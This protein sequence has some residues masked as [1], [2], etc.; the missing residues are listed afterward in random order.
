[1][2]LVQIAL[3]GAMVGVPLGYAMQRTNLCFNAAYR[4]ALLRRN[5][6]LLRGITLAILVQMLGLALLVQLG[7]G[8][9][10]LNVVPFHWLAAIVGGFIMVFIALVTKYMSLGSIT[11]AV[12]AFIMLIILN[13]F[14]VSIF[15]LSPHIA[16]VVY[17]M[18][19]AVFIYIMHRDNIRRLVTGKER[20]LGEKTGT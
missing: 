5:T 8:G 10:Q 3:L 20:K 6:V 18:I 11:G 12:I 19:G 15:N 9:V 7:V 1:M 2:E 4:E 13:Y 16:Y 17:T 14:D